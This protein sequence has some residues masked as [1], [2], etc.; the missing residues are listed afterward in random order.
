MAGAV[1]GWAAVNRVA[2]RRSQRLEDPVAPELLEFPVD[3]EEL[4][5]RTADGWPIR[6]FARGPLDGTPVVLLHGIT[7]SAHIWPYQM[8]DL[9]DAGFRV[10]AVDLRGH[11]GS[12]HPAKGSGPVFGLTLNRL[13]QDVEEVLEHLDLAGVVLVGHS[14]GG[15]VALRMMG[16]HA[17]TRSGRGRIQALGLVATAANVSQGRGVPGLGDAVAVTQPLISRGARLASRLPG[18]TLPAHDLGYLLARVTFGSDSSARQVRFTGAMTSA[19]EAKVSGQ[20]LVEILRYDEQRRLHQIALPTAVVVGDHD[21]MTPMAQSELMAEEIPG[22]RLTVLPGCGH[23]VMLERPAEL[24]QVIVDL[25]A[26]MAEPIGTDGAA[27]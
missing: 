22:A 16:R 7:L 24:N 18:P 8:R 4:L 23:M 12:A 9:A 21:L 1:A 11:G 10:V 19:V 14:M 25:A 20:L 17:G 5:I 26:R 2:V 27:P 3:V 15:M 6:V 13:A